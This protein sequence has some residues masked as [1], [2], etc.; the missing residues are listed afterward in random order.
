MEQ[1]TAYKGMGLKG[2]PKIGHDSSQQQ[3]LRKNWVW[4]EENALGT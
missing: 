1:H 4:A 2:G 3:L